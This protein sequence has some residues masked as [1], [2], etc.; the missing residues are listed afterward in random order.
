MTWA[1]DIL[2]WEVVYLNKGGRQDNLG[3]TGYV[4]GQ[5]PVPE[6]RHRSMNTAINF[7]AEKKRN[8]NRP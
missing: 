4:G 2:F 8:Y 3:D 6:M 5:P 7:E 1:C